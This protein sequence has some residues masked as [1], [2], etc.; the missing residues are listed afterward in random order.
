MN[1]KGT[2]SDSEKED[3]AFF[4]RDFSECFA[5]MRHYDEQIAAISKFAFGAYTT[6]IGGALALYK[7]GVQSKVDYRP[8]ALAV[9]AVAFLVGLVM[10]TMLVTNRLYFVIIARYVN[11][12]RQFFLKN[13]PLGF[14]NETEIYTNPKEPRYF[15][16]RS[17]QSFQFYILALLNAAVIGVI[18]FFLVGNAATLVLG[19]ASVAFS[20]HVIWA[21]WFLSKRE[22]PDVGSPVASSSRSV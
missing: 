16:W 18:A 12:Q 15:D 4:G 2:L 22:K 9:L 17:T 21:I 14:V 13:N 5:Q 7:Y 10:F 6:A 8:A 19:A 11:A 3:A 20:G 1:G